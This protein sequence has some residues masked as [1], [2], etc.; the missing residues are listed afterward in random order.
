MEITELEDIKMKVMKEI[1]DSNV[2]LSGL[3][4]DIRQLKADKE[5]FLQVREDQL[6]SRLS[7][8]LQESKELVDKTEKN[9]IHVHNFYEELS[10]FATI[11]KEVNDKVTLQIKDFSDQCIIA[12]NRIKAQEMELST[13]RNQLNQDLNGIKKDRAFIESQKQDLLN[14]QRKLNSDRETLKR[15]VERLKQGKI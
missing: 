14:G 7:E 1:A 13:L 5:E 11:I 10:Q 2:I 12:E 3:Q 4:A 9:Y 15:A 8:Y 6:M